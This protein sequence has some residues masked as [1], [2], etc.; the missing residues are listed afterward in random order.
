[1]DRF[2]GEGQNELLELMTQEVKTNADY[3]VE[4]ESERCELN[5][6]MLL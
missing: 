6:K 1:M 3:C 4:L 2:S 5:A